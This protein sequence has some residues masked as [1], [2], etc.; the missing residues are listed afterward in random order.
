[1]QLLKEQVFRKRQRLHTRVEELL[2]PLLE[3]Q[4]YGQS[5]WLDYVRRHLLTSGELRSLVDEDGVCG[6][7]SNLSIFEK[8]LIGSTDY[9]DLIEAAQKQEGREAKALYESFA[10]S[11]V[12]QA[13]DILRSVY[14]GTARRDGYVSF[15]FSPYLAH[16]TGG[17]I[18]EARSLRKTVGRDNVMIKVPA[19]P[20]GIP[21]IRQLVSEGINVN[22]TLLFSRETYRQ[23]AEAYIAGL[24]DRAA[25]GHDVSRVASVAGFYV[26]R[27]DTAIENLVSGK[28]RGEPGWE[29]R[30]RLSYLV[31]KVA[32]ANAKLAYQTFK[33]IYRS[34]RW[35]ALA[36]KGAS[37]QRLL[38][39]STSTKNPRLSDVFYVEELIGPDTVS[40][41]PPAT[42]DAFRARGRPRASLEENLEEAVTVMETLE[43]TGISMKEVADRLLNDGIRLLTESFDRLLTALEKKCDGVLASSIDRMSYYLPSRLALGVIEALHEWD[44]NGKV[45]RLWS[46]DASLWTNQDENKW[47]DWLGITEIQRANRRRFRS[48]ADE[49]RIAGFT[50]AVVLGMGGSSLCAEVLTRTFGKQ[51]G[52][53]ELL[54]LDSTDPA[55]IRALETRIDLSKTLFIVSSKSGTTLEPSIFADYFFDRVRQ[56]VGA[57]EAGR[58]FMAITDPGSKL[59]QI[60]EA[61]RFRQVFP[62]VPGIGG[63]YSALS[64][65]GMVPAAVM[66]L[67]VP[68]LIESAE[69]MVHACAPSVP[70]SENPG[71]L[72]GLIMGI[73]ARNGRDKV[74]LV[75]SP[76]ISALGGW[77]GQLLGESTGKDG[78]GLIP[79]DLEPL[80]QPEVYGND[81]LFIYLRLDRE[82]DATQDAAMD[83]LE[84]AGQP[85]VRIAIAD[86]YHLGQEFFRWEIA[87]AVAGS[88]LGINPFNQPD[89]EASKIE[90]RK[91]TAEYQR[92]GTRPDRPPILQEGNIRLFADEKNARELAEAAGSNR[93]LR[94]YLKAHLDRLR[95]GDYFAMLAYVERNPFHLEQLQAIRHAILNAAHVATCLG[96]GPRFLH[97]TGQA[98]KGGPNTGVFLQI[99][100][101]DADELPVPG[102]RLS[103]GVVKAAQACGDLHVLSRR[104]RRVLCVHLGSDVT[105][106]LETLYEVIGQIG[107][108]ALGASASLK[109][110][111]ERSGLTPGK[112]VEAAGTQLA[113][114]GARNDSTTELTRSG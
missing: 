28:L 16:D 94:G 67:D 22:A 99:T 79:V 38:W 82:A 33:E 56:T 105:A 43:Q 111:Q 110:R 7:S 93:S 73:L 77:L 76:R 31:G 103:F 25:Q 47:L 29:E 78:K 63:R 64:D 9:N 61:S 80:G 18:Q 1:M 57:S 40:T 62:G 32:I 104:D 41:V 48:I 54:V 91:L 85:V 74:T 26:S 108:Q 107:M 49:V 88:V 14:R 3:V 113:E 23:V 100:C 89:V 36:R 109:E 112:I 106:G 11:D 27:I 114:G 98:Y 95:C 19:T 70:A 4:K 101:D 60:A 66:G 71:V 72:L 17:I 87:T 13:A 44:H 51:A 102:Q 30:T 58:R 97:S 52:Y 81:R 24:E 50:H 92:T 21:A 46:R 39:A 83:A 34:E 37:P 68:R 69:V 55:Q 84:K 96:F 20:E 8:T 75:I 42:L 15:E 12:Q 59:E 45:R 6:V 90:T 5:I 10:V 35:Q 86:R 65:F 53:P 2:N